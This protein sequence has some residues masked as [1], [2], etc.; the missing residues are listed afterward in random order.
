[1]TKGESVLSAVVVP[2]YYVKCGVNFFSNY[3]RTSKSL[4][5]QE[6]STDSME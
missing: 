2:L 5:N 4:P 3:F 1:M 6:V